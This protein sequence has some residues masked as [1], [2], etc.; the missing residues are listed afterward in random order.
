MGE[1]F[2]Y[3]RKIVVGDAPC[4]SCVSFR[5]CL[6]SELRDQ[7]PQLP[8]FQIKDIL[9]AHDISLYLT[10]DSAEFIY[11]IRQGFLKLER[12]IADGTTRIVCILGKGH[13]SGLESLVTGVYEQSATS[14]SPTIVCQIPKA[15]VLELMPQLH[16]PILKKWHDVTLKI[17]ECL[18]E[19]STGSAKQKVAR[20]FLL[21]DIDKDGRCQLFGRENVGALL[22]ISEETASRIIAD[23]K[24]NR[25]VCE[26]S[27]NIFERNIPEL[28]S[29]ATGK[30]RG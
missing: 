8:P 10:D 15:L 19:F 13:I 28:R 12:R 21:L 9:L 29:I 6:F 27:Q 7:E 11:F 4:N 23:M 26:V 24:R 30:K 3:M 20:L 25:I 1:R 2:R 5:S 22:G 17:Q 16:G 18:R 14:L